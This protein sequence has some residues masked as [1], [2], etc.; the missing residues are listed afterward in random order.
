[1]E[2]GSLSEKMESY[3]LT[4]SQAVLCNLAWTVSI[5]HSPPLRKPK[6]AMLARTYSPQVMDLESTVACLLIAYGLSTESCLLVLHTSYPVRKSFFEWL[7][8][9]LRNTKLDIGYLDP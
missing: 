9:I 8:D 4:R 2:R 3:F 1:M 6:K 5:G 7:K